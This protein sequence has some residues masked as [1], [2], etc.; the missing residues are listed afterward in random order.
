M[1]MRPAVSAPFR[2]LSCRPVFLDNPSVQCRQRRT[3]R[4]LIN[5]R[6]A[7]VITC[8]LFSLSVLSAIFQVD[9]ALAGTRMSPFWILLELRMTEVVMTTEVLQIVTTDKPTSSFFTGRLPF[10]SP[11]HQCQSTERIPTI[12]FNGLS[13]IKF[14]YFGQVTEYMS[15]RDTD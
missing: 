6:L 13:K 14:I 10:L 2:M 8:S 3:G 9:L 4:T 1:A 7:N 15:F 5:R 12:S 11:N